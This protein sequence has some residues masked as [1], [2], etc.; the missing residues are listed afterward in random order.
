MDLPADP[1]D[2]R[3]GHDA[4]QSI[5][6]RGSGAL[7][8]GR[9]RL[10]QQ[11]RHSIAV[12]RLLP[13]GRSRSVD[14]RPARSEPGCRH[15]CA[16]DTCAGGHPR[17][18]CRH[19]RRH[20]PAD[21]RSRRPRGPGRPHHQDRV[22][23]HRSRRHRRLG[24]RGNRPDARPRRLDGRFGSHDLVGQPRCG[25][26]HLPRPGRPI[27]RRG[28]ADAQA[29]QEGHRRAQRL[30]VGRRP[31]RGSSGP[32]RQPEGNR[33]G[34]SGDHGQGDDDPGHPDGR[35]A[36]V[37]RPGS[38]RA[39]DGPGERP[40]RPV[41][42][43]HADGDLRSAGARRKSEPNSDAVTPRQPLGAPAS[44]ST[45]PPANSGPW[46]RTSRRRRSGWSC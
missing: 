36:A 32:H 22:H 13:G 29:R 45:K 39:A 31:D 14:G 41:G 1:G 12:Q 28:R 42:I 8:A 26:G 11:R 40:Q 20:H 7:H 9:D 5:P 2:E 24:R 3:E 35:A 6:C 25:V 44:N 23:H 10:Q 34:H 18:R 15:S 27:R 37:R 43:Q 46:A 16:G 38:D 19:D 21:R 4:K 17:Q 33:E 30:P